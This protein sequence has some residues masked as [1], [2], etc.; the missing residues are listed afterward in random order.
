MAHVTISRI[1]SHCHISKIPIFGF[2]VSRGLEELTFG[3][4]C[5][6]IYADQ[7]HTW[8][9]TASI[10]ALSPVDKFWLVMRITQGHIHYSKHVYR[11]VNHIRVQCLFHFQPG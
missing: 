1:S 8:V 3:V 5:F 2:P 11:A 6:N 10:S 7:A 9:L 4:F